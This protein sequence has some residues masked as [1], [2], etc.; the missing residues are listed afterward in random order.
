MGSRKYH[1]GKRI[2]KAAEMKSSSIKPHTDSAC[3][4]MCVCVF[5]LIEVQPAPLD[6]GGEELLIGLRQSFEYEL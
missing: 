1:A 6:T 4:C 2:R 5:P 3:A